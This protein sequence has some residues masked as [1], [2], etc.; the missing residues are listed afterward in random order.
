MINYQVLKEKYLSFTGRL[1]RKAFNLRL[2]AILVLELIIILPIL[3]IFDLDIDSFIVLVNCLSLIFFI[4][5]L[6]LHIRRLHDLNKS[7]WWLFLLFV[8]FL[9]LF[10]C[11]YILF[12]KGTQGANK[13]GLDLLE[14]ISSTI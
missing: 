1:N 8:P 9:N 7:G 2:L 4:P 3:L 11:I 12:F 13:Y 10:F 5:S 6:S 14:C